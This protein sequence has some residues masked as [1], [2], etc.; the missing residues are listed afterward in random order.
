VSDRACQIDMDGTRSIGGLDVLFRQYAM[1]YQDDEQ[2]V[3]PELLREM[4][5]ALYKLRAHLHSMADEYGLWGVINQLANDQGD[6]SDFAWID[7]AKAE[8]ALQ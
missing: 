8:G 2:P 5:T 6:N 1:A 4:A 3:P 7:E